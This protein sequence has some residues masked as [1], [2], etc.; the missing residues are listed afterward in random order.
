MVKIYIGIDPGASGGIAAIRHDG[1]GVWADAWKWEDC[2]EAHMTLHRIINKGI[3]KRSAEA[4]LENVHAFPTDGR[5]S[6]F[7]FGMNFGMWRGLL[8]A[9]MIKYTLVTPQLWMNEYLDDGEKL[10]KIKKEK[11][12]QLKEWSIEIA[13]KLQYD[14]RVTLKTADAILIAN[15]LS[16]KHLPKEDQIWL[17]G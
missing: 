7:K 16:N 11:K 8:E 5:S 3:K 15:C 9:N 4:W 6:A 17:R 1:I 10:P 13:K 14:K 2:Y 12:Q